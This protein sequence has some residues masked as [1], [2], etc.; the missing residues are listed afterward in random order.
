M[1]IV[2]PAKICSIKL[3]FLTIRSKNVLNFIP[4]DVCYEKIS[5]C[6]INKVHF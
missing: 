4:L 1:H 2:Q 3:Y 6:M 5:C